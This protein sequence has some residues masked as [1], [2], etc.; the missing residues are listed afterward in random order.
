MIGEGRA[1]LDDKVSTVLALTELQM[2][3]QSKGTPG[4]DADPT[5]TPRP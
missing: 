1:S 3:E 2:A 4:A 5:D